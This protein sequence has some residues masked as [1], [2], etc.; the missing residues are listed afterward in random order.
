MAD[1]DIVT[2]DAVHERAADARR[3]LHAARRRPAALPPEQPDPTDPTD[4]TP[5]APVGTPP[6]DAR[7]AALVAENQA[8]RE[9]IAQLREALARLRD[10]AARALDD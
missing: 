3:R 9:E 6:P 10:A 4:P 1:D 7:L 5:A 8:L 2:G